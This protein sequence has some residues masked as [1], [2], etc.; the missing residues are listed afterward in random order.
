MKVTI[1]LKSIKLRLVVEETGSK[2]E[3]SGFAT[4]KM[5]YDM[6]VHPSDPHSRPIRCISE[7][8]RCNF[9]YDKSIPYKDRI[10]FHLIVVNES[11]KSI[12]PNF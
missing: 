1:R 5:T 12:R 6:S 4:K 8:Y 3:S 9:R 2:H 11:N 7:L 10:S